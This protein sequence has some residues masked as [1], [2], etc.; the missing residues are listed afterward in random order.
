[1][2]NLFIMSEPIQDMFLQSAEMLI[3][4]ADTSAFVP[5][6]ATNEESLPIAPGQTQ[7]PHFTHITQQGE[8]PLVPWSWHPYDNNFPFE[9][10]R[11][12]F[13]DKDAPQIISRQ[14]NFLL[15]KGDICLFTEDGQK[16]KLDR[17]H[18][19]AIW[20]RRNKRQM[21]K[22]LEGI[23]RNYIMY[24]NHFVE[25]L[26]NRNGTVAEL[27]SID[28]HYMRC[29]EM[30]LSGRIENY[31]MYRQLHF[32][33]Y[34]GE[35][36]I[37]IPAFREQN[38]TGAAVDGRNQAP[39]F[40]FHGRTCSP[41]N[42]YYGIPDWIGGVDQ[43]DLRKE[44]T[45]YFLYGLKNGFNIRYLLKIHPQFYNGC[46]SESEKK[47]KKDE[48]VTELNSVLQ[49]SENAGKTIAVNMVKQHL[50]KDYQGV[51]DIVP[52]QN[53]L[54]DANYQG[55][56]QLTNTSTPANFG[57]SSVLAGI[58]RAGALSSGSE[59][60]NQY[61]IHQANI[62]RPRQLVLEPIE[63][64]FELNGWTEQYEGDLYDY[65]GFEDWKLTPMA[66]NKSG[67]SE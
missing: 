39:V 7:H 11:Y 62:Q 38:R 63:L 26:L 5:N 60:L 53:N 22:L 23:V 6:Q 25:F 54:S 30:S 48:L 55:L 47:A 24:G 50:D 8:R 31:F 59:A 58:E 10:N 45:K 1:M 32:Q 37:K 51:I 41:G 52:I 46:K 20:K 2:D 18:P 27:K 21:K 56:M 16:V 34:G 57:I 29:E 9:A 3:I 40:I 43:L 35:Q 67:V 19:I 14:T 33:G 66:E 12:I 61:N 15:G 42:P 49:G 4:D 28:A 36:I 65:I 13:G 64:L 44:I 17:N